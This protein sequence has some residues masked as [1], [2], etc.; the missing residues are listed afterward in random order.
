MAVLC[1]LLLRHWRVNRNTLITD[2]PVVG[3]FPGVLSNVSR[4][5]EFT[6]EVLQ[7]GGGTVEIKGPWFTNSL[8][9]MVTCDPV[10]VQHIMT[11]SFANYPKGQD[12]KTI[13][14]PLGDGIFNSD[15]DLWKYQRK[16]FQ[17]LIGQTKFES[18]MEKTI[19][20]K[21]VH[22]LFPVLDY[23]STTEIQVNEL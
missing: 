2:W 4:L 15:S 17:S 14:E 7:I 23:V 18:Y 13:F 12:Y 20:R 6:V 9:F 8:D 21:V 5:H 16:M 22:G 19:H 11:K 1:F 10:N 3:M